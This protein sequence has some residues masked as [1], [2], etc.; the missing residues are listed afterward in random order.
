MARAI[1]KKVIFKTVS[2]KALIQQLEG[3][4]SPY[5]VYRM[6]STTKFERPNPP[7]RPYRWL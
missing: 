4:E 6:G 2:A 7:G 1:S 5:P 3:P